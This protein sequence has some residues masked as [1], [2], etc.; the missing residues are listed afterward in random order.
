MK[1]TIKHI[2]NLQ[3]AGKIAG[4][5]SCTVSAS[6]VEKQY[7][8]VTKQPKAVQEIEK[9]LQNVGIA[10]ESEYRFHSDR[11]FRFDF[12]IPDKKIAIEYEGLGYKKTGHTTSEG[13]TSNCEKYNLATSL[14]WKVYRYTYRNY[15]NFKNDLKAILL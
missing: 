7:K 5:Q 11:R 6:T 13:Y 1:W 2:E 8:T 9:A 3:S 15:K 14:G 10:Y 4:F 12:A